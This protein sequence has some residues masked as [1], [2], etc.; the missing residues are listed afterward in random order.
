MDTSY[1]VALI[2]AIDDNH[3]RAEEI[4]VGI[5]NG[6]YGKLR[7]SDYV[8]VEAITVVRVR[9]RRHDLAVRVAEMISNSVMVDFI[10]VTKEELQKA[11]KDYKR[12]ADKDLSIADWVSVAQI[13]MRG[14]HGILSFDSG[15]DQVSVKRIC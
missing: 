15:F 10:T 2:S 4:F 14:M 9:T 1:F 11:L 3:A 8:L 5:N 7:A 13:E 12:K 6:D